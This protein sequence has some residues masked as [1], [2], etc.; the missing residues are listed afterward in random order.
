MKA[1]KSVIFA[2]LVIQGCA[3]IPE[4]KIGSSTNDYVSG[5]VSQSGWNETKPITFDSQSSP[6]SLV[7]PSEVPDDI[8]SQK[9]IIESPSYLTTRD[10]AFVLSSAGVQSA[11]SGRSVD[12][13][14]QESVRDEVYVPSFDGTVGSFIDMIS[15]TTDMTF[16][17]S[18]STLIIDKERHYIVRIPQQKELIASIKESLVSMGASNITASQESGSIS[19]TASNAG[20]RAIDSYLSEISKNTSVINTQIMILKVAIDSNLN[21]GFDWSK[22]A[23]NI[24]DKELSSN[25][26]TTKGLLSSVSKNAFGISFSDSSTSVIAAVNLLSTYGESKIAQNISTSTISGLSTTIRSGGE[27]PYISEISTSAT[28]GASNSG[29]KTEVLKTGLTINIQPSY[30]A[31]DRIVTLDLDVALRSLVKFRDLSAGDQLGTL[32]LPETQDNS[33]KNIVKLRAGESILLG[34]LIIDSQSDNRRN[35][36]LLKRFPTGSE[37]V[38]KKKEAIFFM[39]RPT[40]TVFDG[41]DA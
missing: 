36:S 10:I 41:G 22:L 25:A 15:S 6:I 37:D 2:S 32:S 20:Q 7:S 40:V 33:L 29:V 38:S 1:I 26:L 28:D 11:I 13:K 3:S 21:Q 23:V 17:W 12:P 19:Y 27:I 30:S 9:L 18:G 34:G 4:P 24:G 5:I 16:S 39:L 14:E 8:R 31:S 35:L